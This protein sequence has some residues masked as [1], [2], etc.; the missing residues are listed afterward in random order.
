MTCEPTVR[1]HLRVQGVWI[2]DVLSLELNVLHRLAENTSSVSLAGQ[3]YPFAATWMRR[4]IKDH[5][6]GW[7]EIVAAEPDADEHAAWLAL[8]KGHIDAI[9]AIQISNAKMGLERAKK[10]VENGIFD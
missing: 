10:K 3:E 4:E 6:E 9:V 7:S 2:R 8:V 5:A 1:A